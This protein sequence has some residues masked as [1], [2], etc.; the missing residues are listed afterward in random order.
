MATFIKEFVVKLPEDETLDFESG[1][2]IQV[3]VPPLEVDF[4]KDLY[5]ISEEYRSDYDKFGIWDLKMK[6][7]EPIFRAY[8]MAKPPGGR[9]HHYVE[10]PYRH[11]AVEPR[12]KYLDGCKPR[13]LFLIRVLT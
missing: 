11:A 2:Y 4:S 12:R 1:G 9:K 7:D 5:N 10:Y 3:D 8:S 13:H 6:N